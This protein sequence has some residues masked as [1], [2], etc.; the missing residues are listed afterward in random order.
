M[1][2]CELQCHRVYKMFR[3][4]RYVHDREIMTIILI[5]QD[6]SHN[7]FVICLLIYQDYLIVKFH[8]W[9]LEIYRNQF[10]IVRSNTSTHYLL[11]YYIIISD[12]CT[13]NA[14][15]YFFC[16]PYYRVFYRWVLLVHSQKKMCKSC[17]WGESKNIPLRH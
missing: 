11:S 9:K 16:F 2:L 13:F 7:L 17:H 10:R 6:Y 8:T 4:V 1:F 3:I 5:Y 12:Y 15:K 14:C